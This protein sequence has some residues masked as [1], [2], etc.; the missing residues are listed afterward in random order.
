MPLLT[1][2]PGEGATRP[3]PGR[4]VG[5]TETGYRV[6]MGELDYVGLT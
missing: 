2:E 4:S 1:I 6:L 5:L 3:F